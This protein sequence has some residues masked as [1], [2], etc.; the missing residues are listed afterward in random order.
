MMSRR[1]L[2]A[3][4][5]ALP[6]MFGT[7]KSGAVDAYHEVAPIPANSFLTLCYHNVEDEDPDQKY[8]SVASARLV[9]QISWLQHVGYQA[10]SL[11]D[12]LA[13]RAGKKQ[14]P[15]K[16][17]L[18]TFDDGY[19]SF[20]TRVYP[21]LKAFHVPAVIGVVDEWMTAG[22]SDTDNQGDRVHYVPYGDAK[23]PRDAFL[24]WD[25]VREMQKSGLVEVASHSHELH[26]GLVAN[27]QGNTEPSATTL[28]YDPKTRTYETTESYIKRIS[29][30]AEASARTIAKE[31]GK[32]P[33]AMIWPYGSANQLAMSIES[34]HGMPVTMTLDDGLGTVDHLINV[35]RQLVKD[36]PGMV[37]FSI[38]AREAAKVD[39]VRVIQVDLDYVYDKDPEQ[40]DRNVGDLVN[41]IFSMGINTVFL[42]AFADPE[43]TGLAKE[44]YFPNR[45]LPMRADLFNRVAWQLSSRADI[46]VYGWLPVLSYDFGGDVAEVQALNTKTGEIGVDPKAYHRLSPFDTEARAKI[47]GIYEDFGRNAPI[48]GILFHDDAVL[49]DFEDASPAAMANYRAA[50]FPD[51]IQEIRRDP[52]TMKR[53]TAF[54]T[55]ALI[56][57]TKELAARVHK[58]RSPLA[59]ARNIYAPV[60]MSPESEAWFAQNYDK[61]L[62]A[63]DFTAVEAMP[64]MEQIPADQSEEWLNKLV[65][66]SAQH[67][68]ALKHTIFELQAV[69]WRKQ[70]NGNDRLIPVEKL[71]GEMRLLTRRGALNFGYYPDDFVTGTPDI[72]ALHKDFSLQT[73]PYLP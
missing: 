48:N 27:P 62:K 52:E 33:R 28:G 21:I 73:Y 42:Q 60:I 40:M 49:S 29:A 43:G 23:L 61:F 35:P 39:P 30:D 51:T 34:E 55:D 24:T 20:Y 9:E 10:V 6:L 4:A 14:L 11:D 32:R 67:P 15:P 59:T 16:A 2:I 53:W 36:D 46:K 8:E 66:L 65:S 25:Q 19:E 68:D 44:L 7:V 26:K 56:D 54:K 72:K 45:Y 50:G 13:A 37:E 5:L 12:I 47:L 1:T 17:F 64:D 70:A 71:S 22:A 57:F 31:T 41:R 63:Y 38:D 18:L 3:C 58:F 69:D